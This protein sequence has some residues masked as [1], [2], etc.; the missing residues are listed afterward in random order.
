M[1]NLITAS[2]AVVTL[3]L[4]TACS[5]KDKISDPADS[6]VEKC[7]SCGELA[8]LQPGEKLVTLETNGKKITLIQSGS[9]YKLDP[10]L[11]LTDRQL[12]ILKGEYKGDEGGRTAGPPTF[13]QLWPSRTVYYTL[14]WNLANPQV[15]ADAIAHWQA[16]TNL[17]FVLRTNQPNFIEFKTD[18]NAC[19][20]ESLGMK[21]GLQIVNLGSAC[22]VSNAIHEIGHAIGL[23]HELTRKDRDYYVDMNWANIRPEWV[24]Q[25]QTYWE[26]G[27]PGFEIGTMDFSSIMMYGSLGGSSSFDPT[28]P[29]WTDKNGNTYAREDELSDGDIQTYNLLYNPPSISIVRLNQVRVTTPEGRGYEWE[30]ELQITTPFTWPWPLEIAIWVHESH[31]DGSYFTH[32]EHVVLQPGQ[33]TQA[34]GSG[35]QINGSSG[36]DSYKRTAA[37]VYQ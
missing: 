11:Y 27:I 2:I 31:F 34:L 25:Y 30:D 33:T 29:V 23:Y 20:S 8:G 32:Y 5:K 24:S 35:W 22:S 28:V 37:T 17:Q 14:H 15:V 10:D 3:L 7:S 9:R 6:P 21:G 4:G 1:R 13:I 18:E 16:N 26:R 36:E 19:W 12:A